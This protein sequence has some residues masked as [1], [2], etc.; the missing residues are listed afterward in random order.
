MRRA[1]RYLYWGVPVIDLLRSHVRHCLLLCCLSLGL[2]LAVPVQ[3]ALPGPLAGVAG[4]GEKVSEAQL[5][6]S[7]DQVIKT[8]ENDQQRADLLK[9]LK[10]LRDASK[11]S[12][13]EQGGVLGLIGDTLGSLEKQFEG[14]NSPMVR[15]GDLFRQG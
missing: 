9:K 14:A 7:L 6:Q 3:A 10:Q 8:L 12:T 13:E 11:K 5:Q 1:F 4:G 2:V 15:W